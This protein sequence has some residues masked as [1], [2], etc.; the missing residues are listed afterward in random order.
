MATLIQIR[1]GTLADATISDPILAV[2]ELSFF[3]DLGKAVLGD[4]ATHAMSLP[5]LWYTPDEV[6]DLFSALTLTDIGAP[7]ANFSM[8]SNRLT[9]VADPVSSQDVVTKA[10]G[11]ANLGGGG[12]GTGDVTG[13]SSSVDSEIALFSGTT[14]KIIKRMTGSGI[15]KVASGVASIASSGTDYAPATSGSAI[16]KGNGSGGFSAAS[17]G[18]D[19]YAPGSTDVAVADGGTGA[20]G[21]LAARVN[22]GLQIGVDVLAPNGSGASLTSIPESAVTNLVTDLAAK[23]PLDSDL[24]TIAGLTATTD[25]FL[26]SVSSA[27]ASRTPSQVRTTLGLVIGTNVQAWDADLDTWAT[28]TPPSGTVVGAA[29]AQTLTNKRVTQR[30]GTTTSSATPSINGD[31]YDGYDITALAAAITSITITGTPTH[32]QQLLLRI[33]DNGT[34]RAI[35]TGSSII[36]SGVASFPTTTVSGM[37]HTILLVWDAVFATKWV[38]MAADAVG[39]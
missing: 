39:Y 31:S 32:N 34:A 20:S 17:A 35:T 25:N 18:S 37:V 23:Q 30:V 33:K 36:S 38:V 3:T 29:D 13:Q 10:W 22:L 6:D 1:G 24:T 4:G 14:G 16:L 19:Y 26:V 2:R 28:K 11:L 27:W 7:T 9:N 15:V 21:A 5:F 8:G 12:G